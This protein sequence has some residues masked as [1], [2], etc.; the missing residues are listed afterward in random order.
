LSGAGIEIGNFAV[1]TGES[2]KGKDIGRDTQWLPSC[3]RSIAALSNVWLNDGI[4]GWI[5]RKRQSFSN[6]SQAISN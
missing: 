1:Q 6:L 3:G 4:D 5:T 2:R